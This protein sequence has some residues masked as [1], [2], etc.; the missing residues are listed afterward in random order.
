M[1]MERG[2]LLS[3]NQALAQGAWEAGVRVGTGYPGTPSTEI[4]ETLVKLGDVDCEW[5]PNEKVALEVA[6]GAS[7]GG[8]RAL[9]TMKHV[10]L[11]VAADPLFSVAY[12]GVG[13]G[14]VVVSADD[15]GMHSS[16]N[17]QDN[18]LL[19]RAARIALLEPSTPEEARTYAAA[20][21]ELSE[22]YDTPVLLRTTTRLA[23]GTGEAFP[24]ERMEPPARPYRKN[25]VKN[26]V[27]P[28][29]GR[30]RHKHIEEQRLPALAAEAE[31]WVTEIAGDGDVAII[32]SGIPYLYAREA[33][34]NAPVLKLGLT[35]PLPVAAIRAFAAKHPRL[36]V[37]EELE[38]Y[39]EEQ[40]RA[41]G[42]ACEPRTWPRFGELSAELLRSDG[43]SGAVPTP[44]AALPPLP[45]RPPALC[46]GC[47]HRGT[48]HTLAR[49]DAVVSGD[50]GCYTLGALPPLDAMDS[51]MN[52]GASIGMARG[53]AKALPAD[54]TRPKKPVVAVI[55]DST[56]FHS[57]ITG[58]VD[59][60]YNGGSSTVVVMDN[61]TTAMTGH[62]GHPGTG[63]R[64]GGGNGI[65]PVV[66][67]DRVARAVGIRDVQHLPPYDLLNAW[68]VLDA[69]ARSKEPSVLI[70]EAPCVLNQRLDLGDI[71]Q[72]DPEKCT[73][74]HACT[75]LGCPAIEQVDGHIEVNAALCT[76]CTHCQ[77]V[78][79]DCNAGI[80]VPLVLELVAQNRL[81]EAVDVLLR[82][83][84]LPS[85]VSLVCP[86]PCD[87]EVN[88]LGLPQAKRYAYQY[89]GLLE[90]FSEVEGRISVR[91]VERF[92][93]EHALR[94]MDPARFGPAQTRNGSVAI[95]GSG[96]AGLSA[97]WQLRR[98]GWNVTVLEAA[99]EPGGMLRWGIPAFRLPRHLLDGEIGRLEAIG[100]QI[101]CGMRLGH[102][103]SLEELSRDH[104]AVVL[105][106]GDGAARALRLE[107]ADEVASG[108]M[109]GV[110]FLARYNAGKAPPVGQR[111]AIVGG[112][113]TAIDCA[114]AAVRL[115]AE[116]VVLYRRAQEEMPAIPEEVEEARKEFV[117]FAFRRLPVR[118]VAG[119]DGHLAGVVTVEMRPGEPDA[120]GRRRPEPVAGTEKLEAYDL[121]VLAVGEEADLAFLQGTELLAGERNRI[122]VNFAGAT[123][124]AGVFACGDAAF[125]QGT[126]AQAIATGRRA[127][128]LVS[129][130]MEKKVGS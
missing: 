50:I 16:Q 109:S 60:V 124:R 71:V 9:A 21:F 91:R 61:G 128:E 37:V 114:R 31:R 72:L 107:G 65:A 76:G 103:L 75:R 74:C 89:P 69:A 130:Y 38:P 80:D 78:C 86:H 123:R 46:P 105:A 56:F 77:Q 85:V 116:A 87:H 4:L 12:M 117:R 58:L 121:V 48:F 49:M 14:L 108:I 84:P 101:R 6:V 90:R 104:D 112:G 120:D 39:L 68:R 64:L 129:D 13:G 63:G 81:D 36:L 96:P 24:C 100:V 95:V 8:A 10:G 110:D 22:R 52:M 113:N 42:I 11:N 73:D 99:A 15:P 94:E 27:L 45:V 54:G 35:H 25:R 82:T 28:A 62:Q 59:L 7:L 2:K 41:L 3:G 127:A 67:I 33:F 88:A 20:A 98:R 5:S 118:V 126:V 55:G 66:D 1:D 29:H 43:A 47:S 30:I 106:V 79:A 102:D 122:A 93:G 17:E 44:G 92:L 83:N 51:C 40:V 115:D 111:V 32:T 125:G 119:A 34:P 97:A 18:R 26:V 23:H 57:G 19:A 53:L 70:A